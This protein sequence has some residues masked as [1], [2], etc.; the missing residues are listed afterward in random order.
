VPALGR[1]DT[2]PRPAHVNPEWHA[3]IKA[4]QT[5]R[6]QAELAA[7]REA[8]A[9]AYPVTDAEIALYGTQHRDPGTSAAEHE[10]LLAAPT[11]HDDPRAPE[12][13]SEYHARMQSYAQWQPEAHPEAST[14]PETSHEAHSD[15][16]DHTEIEL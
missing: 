6:V 9:R 13:T 2:G 1:D 3:Q 16:P 12:T 5:A 15:T 14:E 8:S 4:A 7:R 11:E 10:P